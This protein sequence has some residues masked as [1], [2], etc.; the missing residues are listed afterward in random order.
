MPWMRLTPALSSRALVSG[1]QNAEP[2]CHTEWGCACAGTAGAWCCGVAVL[3]EHILDVALHGEE[4]CAFGVVPCKV[5]TGVFLALP[6]FSDGVVLLEDRSEV[7]DVAFTNVFN[8]KVVGNEG[9]RDR[10]PLV[11]P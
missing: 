8:A 6:V 4:T 10:A 1:G 5:D 7:Q 9:E 2:W 3:D 11:L